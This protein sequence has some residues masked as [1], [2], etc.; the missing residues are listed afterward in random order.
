MVL[1]V[2]ISG[3][4][5][6]VLGHLLGCFMARQ[7]AVGLFMGLFMGNTAEWHLNREKHYNLGGQESLV[8]LEKV[9]V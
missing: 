2:G 1:E 6:W 8:V 5:G 7:V 4:K 9:C 3:V